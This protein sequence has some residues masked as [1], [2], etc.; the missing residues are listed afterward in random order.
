MFL[1]AHSIINEI[2]VQCKSALTATFLFYFWY[3]SC[4][5][6]YYIVMCIAVMVPTC[7]YAARKANEKN[8]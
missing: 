8:M 6:R 3:T 1:Y 7:S 2:V 4:F 5:E